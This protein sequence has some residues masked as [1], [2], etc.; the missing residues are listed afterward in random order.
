VDNITIKHHVQYKYISQCESN[1]ANI[2]KIAIT[3]MSQEDY[4]GIKDLK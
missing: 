3:Q 2:E 4:D 1:F